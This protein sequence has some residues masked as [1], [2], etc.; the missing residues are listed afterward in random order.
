MSASCKLCGITQTI[1]HVLAGCNTMLEQGRCTWRHHCVL[2]HLE[3]YIR[4]LT[5]NANIIIDLPS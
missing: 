3:T 2:N 5:N 4:D 1:L